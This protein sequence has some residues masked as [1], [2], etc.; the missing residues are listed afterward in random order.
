MKRHPRAVLLAVA[1]SIVALLAHFSTYWLSSRAF[2]L[3][4]S[5]E[6]ILIIMPLVD[7]LT[8]LPVTLYGIGLRETLFESLLGGIYGIAPGAATL[9]S[10]GGFSLQ[11]L[12]AL[13]GGLLI[14]FTTPPK[15]KP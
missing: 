5:P 14:P 3:P 15:Q 1:L 10:L 9:A 13:S 11:A 12:V 2:G 7:T 4:L 8:M 6:D